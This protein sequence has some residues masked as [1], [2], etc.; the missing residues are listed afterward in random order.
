GGGGAAG[1]GAD[2][3][4]AHRSIAREL[5]ERGADGGLDQLVV[6]LGK[7]RLL[8]K[9]FQGREIVLEEEEIQRLTVS[10]QDLGQILAAA[11]EQGVDRLV[12]GIFPQELFDTRARVH[13]TMGSTGCRPGF[14]F[15][16]TAVP[17]WYCTLWGMEI[18]YCRGRH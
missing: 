8:V 5:R 9:G 11:R 17:S 13:D 2:F 7:R 4:D 15:I 14:E 12:G 16:H 10:P 6:E 1:T 18:L 3:E